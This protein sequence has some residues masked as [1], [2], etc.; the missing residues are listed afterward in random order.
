MTSPDWRRW[1]AWLPAIAWAAFLFHLSSLPGL[2]A[3]DGVDDK[4][5]HAAAYSVLAFCC[6]IGLSGASLRRITPALLVTALVLAVCYGV[7]D[8]L[9]QA[10]VPGREPD[11]AD[12]FA[13]AVG[14]LLAVALVWAWAILLRRRSSAQG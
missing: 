11:V 9:H 5:A 12:V 13:D 4:Q 7:S 10:F 1:A 3:L 14:A 6:V 2:P 8:E